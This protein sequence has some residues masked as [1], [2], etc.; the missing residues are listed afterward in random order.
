MSAEKTKK[1]MS[2]KETKD[3]IFNPLNNQ[4]FKL[5]GCSICNDWSY[6]NIHDK[7][8]ILAIQNTFGL[9]IPGMEFTT[10]KHKTA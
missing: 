9:N 2:A 7:H 5:F 1:N 4:I 6:K 10:K 3:L 8:H